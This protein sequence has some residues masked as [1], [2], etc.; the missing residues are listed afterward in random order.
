MVVEIIESTPRFNR[1]EVRLKLMLI[2]LYN[3]SSTSPPPFYCFLYIGRSLILFMWIFQNTNYCLMVIGVPNVG[4]SSL[5]NALRRTYLKKGM[6][7]ITECLIVIGPWF[8][9]I[10]KDSSEKVIDV[11]ISLQFQVVHLEWAGSQ[12]LLKRSW[13][14]FRWVWKTCLS[15]NTSIYG[16]TMCTFVKYL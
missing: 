4:K 14:K 5:I 9:L 2:K 13:L 1:D 16:F 12:V 7:S 11:V 15:L 6:Y 10:A 3:L 8:S